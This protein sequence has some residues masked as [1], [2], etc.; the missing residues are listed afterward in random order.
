MNLLQIATL[1]IT[2]FIACAEF[3]SYAFVHPV[4]GRL[5][6]TAPGGA[7]LAANLRPGNAGRD[8]AVRRTRD[9]ERDHVER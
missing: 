7:R 8:D 2:G 1:A 6:P 4:V 9:H 5:Q 3:G